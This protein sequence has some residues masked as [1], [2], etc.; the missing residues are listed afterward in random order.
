LAIETSCGHVWGSLVAQTVKNPPAMQETWV[1][2]LGQENPLEKGI[3]THSRFLL[4]ESH[5]QR[6]G[7]LQSIT[8]AVTSEQM[9]KRCWA[10]EQLGDGRAS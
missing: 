7:G 10:P 2:F 5:G 4:G 9:R 1:Q 8:S 3:A 6:T